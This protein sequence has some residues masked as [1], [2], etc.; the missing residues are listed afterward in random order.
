MSR[1]RRVVLITGLAVVGLSSGLSSCL[2]G[3][4]LAGEGRTT[5]LVSTGP[6]GGNGVPAAAYKGS[7]ADGTRV[8]FQ[9]SES[10]VSSDTDNFLP[11]TVNRKSLGTLS[12]W[13]PF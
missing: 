3:T 12:P 7:S 13:V 4:A 8:F 5:D 2:T 1:I 11:S 9:T 10:L 6:T